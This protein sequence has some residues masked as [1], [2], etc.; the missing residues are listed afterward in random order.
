[1]YV[2]PGFPI[3]TTKSTYSFNATAIAGQLNGKFAI[4]LIGVDTTGTP[5]QTWGIYL[6]QSN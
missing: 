2:G 4:F 3:N 1:V 6:L 5:N